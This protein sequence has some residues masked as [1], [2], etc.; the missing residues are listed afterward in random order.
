[1]PKFQT[2]RNTNL[3]H[4]TSFRAPALFL[5]HLN[6]F[7]SVSQ[8]PY[9]WYDSFAILKNNYSTALKCV[10][11]VAVDYVCTTQDNYPQ[12][13]V[14]NV[15]NPK[16]MHLPK[17][18]TSS[19]AQF[20]QVFYTALMNTFFVLFTSFSSALY[21]LSTQPIITIYLNKRVKE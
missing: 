10:S 11:L 19:Y 16:F 4:N 17:I 8:S 7:F 1:M 13:C 20:I 15:Y 2:E 18:S 12:A 6:S 9:S 21:T 14:Q 3:C 5:A